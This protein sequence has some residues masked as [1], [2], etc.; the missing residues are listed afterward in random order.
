MEFWVW[1]GWISKRVYRGHNLEHDRL[2][3]QR[4][5]YQ[6]GC[7]GSFDSP[8]QGKKVKNHKGIFPYVQRFN[9]GYY[10]GDCIMTKYN[11]KIDRIQQ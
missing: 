8:E 5:I 2:W 6:S 10:K 9:D 4:E 7:T 1:Q 3:Y 11:G